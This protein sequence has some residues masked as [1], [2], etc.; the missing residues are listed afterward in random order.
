MDYN[1]FL[2]LFVL[3]L[4]LAITLFYI[5]RKY[6][7]T[8]EN[9]PPPV[10]EGQEA[11]QPSPNSSS[12][13]EDSGNVPMG[14]FDENSSSSNFKT[15]TEQ[16]LIDRLMRRINNG[17]TDNQLTEDDMTRMEDPADA[18]GPDMENT[19]PPAD[20]E[21]VRDDS[22]AP[23]DAEETTTTQAALNPDN[24]FPN[25]EL[26][27]NNV[28]ETNQPELAYTSPNL[29][30][31]NQYT[32]FSTEDSN[33]IPTEPEQ[34]D[35]RY[36]QPVLDETTTTSQ[37]T[38]TQATTTTQAPSIDFMAK[39]NDVVNR[40]DTIT[41]TNK[42]A[43]IPNDLI[44]TISELPDTYKN[45]LCNS[46]CSI[47]EK[48]SPLCDV[49]DCINCKVE[50]E[51]DI[52]AKIN[53]PSRVYRQPDEI[54]HNQVPHTI[55]NRHIPQVPMPKIESSGNGENNVFAPYVVVHRK[56]RGEKYNAYVMSNP[57]DPNYYSYINNLS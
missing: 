52:M 28:P 9:V 19:E 31:D 29:N 20:E 2:V 34:P 24:Q 5:N 21:R 30:P 36:S 42:F 4:V 37:P 10:E 51:D 38:T 55:I 40:L 3:I 12:T 46:Y 49:L 23:A 47:Y 22:P 6:R 13:P 18:A 54:Q 14:N 50:V 39:Y 15:E 1:L 11:D 33:D 8:F 32:D 41:M 48:C 27:D 43:P 44:D 56:K 7:E 26:A 16:D 35:L 25:S 57:Y 45:S 53:E 17:T